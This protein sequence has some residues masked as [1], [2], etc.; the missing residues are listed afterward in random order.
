M[1]SWRNKKICRYPFL[2]GSIKAFLYHAHNLLTF[3]SH[4]ATHFSCCFF[5]VR[6]FAEQCHGFFFAK[7]L[8]ALL[9]TEVNHDIHDLCDSPCNNFACCCRNVTKFLKALFWVKEMW[10]TALNFA[11]AHLTTRLFLTT[12]TFLYT[13]CTMHYHCTCSSLAESVKEQ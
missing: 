7:L 2:S 3:I 8:Y 1:F 9:I 4:G 12:Q 13:R 11:L 10:K 6:K 5:S